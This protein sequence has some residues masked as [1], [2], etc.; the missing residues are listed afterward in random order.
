MEELLSVSFSNDMIKLQNLVYT[1]DKLINNTLEELS[2]L[3]DELIN[4]LPE[5]ADK[6][7][8]NQKLNTLSYNSFAVEE[9]LKI[10]EKMRFSKEVVNYE[11]A[12]HKS[13]ILNN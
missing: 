8:I 11:R 10:I 1:M 9:L 13:E 3:E 6:T 12:I 4:Q 2:N 7:I 5:N